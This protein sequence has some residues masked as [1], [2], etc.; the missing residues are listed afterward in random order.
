MKALHTSFK[1]I[2]FLSRKDDTTIK[3]YGRYED[4]YEFT[5]FYHHPVRIDGHM[6]PTTEHYFQAQ[7]FVGTPYYDHIRKLPFP[8]DAFSVS[9]DPVASWWVR[10]DWNRVKEDVMLKALREKFKN[11]RLKDLLVGTGKKKLVEHTANDS[12]WGDGGDG[13]GLNRLGELLMRV[14]DEIR[15]SKSRK[16]GDK[17]NPVPKMIRSIS[18]SDLH[19]GSQLSLDGL[20]TLGNGHGKKK[21]SYSSIHTLTPKPSR[22][23]Y[24]TSNSHEIRWPTAEDI[25][26][27]HLPR[28]DVHHPKRSNESSVKYNILAPPHY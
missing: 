24:D 14:R 23:F 26:T 11:D 3:F 2:P 9:R 27:S 4:Y 7:K 16:K 13:S 15:R 6:W 1:R 8:R 21:A 19:S 20:S 5:N 17:E 22:K 28:R 25:R 18:F 10:G 12:Y